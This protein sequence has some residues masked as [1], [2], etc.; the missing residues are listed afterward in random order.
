MQNRYQKNMT[1]VENRC[2]S[3]QYE[4]TGWES[5]TNTIGKIIIEDPR[6]WGIRFQAATLML[7]GLLAWGIGGFASADVVIDMPPPTATQ[8]PPPDTTTADSASSSLPMTSGQLALARYSYARSQ[9]DQRDIRYPSRFG[10][11]VFPSRRW[12]FISHDYYG[13]ERYRRLSLW[14]WVFW[15]SW[16][17]TI[18]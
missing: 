2:V 1:Y 16:K 18:N 12:Y 8:S 11:Y 14:P 3:I 9:P 10:G 6:M 17:I 15:G 4:R 5:L 13:Y 7:S